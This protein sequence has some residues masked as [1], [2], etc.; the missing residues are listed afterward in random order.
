M[1]NI[2][3]IVVS[4]L[5]SSVALIA[6]GCATSS[7]LSTSE[8]SYESTDPADIQVLTEYPDNYQ[9]IGLVEA[10]APKGYLRK[11]KHATNLAIAAL[12]KQAASLGAHAVVLTDYSSSKVPDL[13]LG[14]DGEELGVLFNTEYKQVTAVAI[15]LR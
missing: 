4:I 3:V 6:T 1:K 9:S 14:G 13:S 7:G 10:S 11:P 2:N 12:K 8:T 5:L 15:R